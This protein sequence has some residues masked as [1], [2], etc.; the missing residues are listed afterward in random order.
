L[1]NHFLTFAGV[2]APLVDGELSIRV[3]EDLKEF[4]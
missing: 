2:E 3:M 1:I 4:L